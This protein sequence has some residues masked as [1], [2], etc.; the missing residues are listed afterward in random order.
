MPDEMYKCE[1]CNK[2][3]EGRRYCIGCDAHHDSLT[4]VTVYTQEEVDELLNN[5]LKR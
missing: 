2:I 1:K 3:M 4:K 5:A